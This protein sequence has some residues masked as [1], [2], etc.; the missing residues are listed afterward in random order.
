[1]MERTRIYRA[2][3]GVRGRAPV[4]LDAL[5]ELLVRFSQLVVEQPRMKEIDIN[6]SARVGRW[7]CR[8]GRES[9]AASF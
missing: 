2:L 1:M 8:A 6:P 9:G 7:N 3:Q 5:E 4:D